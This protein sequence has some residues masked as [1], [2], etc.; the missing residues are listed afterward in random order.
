MMA[1][2]M[3]GGVRKAAAGRHFVL[4]SPAGANGKDAERI[5]TER[6]RTEEFDLKVFDHD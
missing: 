2:F 5:S 6:L 3:H 4:A 1:G